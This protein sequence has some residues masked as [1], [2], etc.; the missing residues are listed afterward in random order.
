M[1]TDLF[2]ENVYLKVV[3]AMTQGQIFGPME[4]ARMI[5]SR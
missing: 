5:E 2:R 3:R 1:M 4:S